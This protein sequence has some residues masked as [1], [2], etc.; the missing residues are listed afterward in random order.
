LSEAQKGN[1]LSNRLRKQLAIDFYSNK[2]F[3]C[4]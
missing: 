2:L 1:V 3:V 4:N